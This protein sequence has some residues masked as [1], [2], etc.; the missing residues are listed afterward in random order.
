[1][2]EYPSEVRGENGEK[3]DESSKFVSAIEQHSTSTFP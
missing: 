3:F 2:F 1:M